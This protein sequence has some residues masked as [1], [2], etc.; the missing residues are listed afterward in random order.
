MTTEKQRISIKFAMSIDDDGEKEYNVVKAVGSYYKK[1]RFD[2]ITYKEA[3][4]DDVFVNNLLTIHK[5]KVSIK[6]TGA[7]QMNQ[8]FDQQRMTESVYQ[9]PHG[10]FH[11][12]TVTEAIHYER[13]TEQSAGRLSIDYNVRLNGQEK[14]KHS[15]LLTF[16]EENKA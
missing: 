10:N 9:H 7:V 14:R 4:D 3:L 6:R 1:E 5:N 8:Q 2:V 13:P 16:Q 15:L 11:M 12:E